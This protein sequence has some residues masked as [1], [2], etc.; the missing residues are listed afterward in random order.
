MSFFCNDH[1]YVGDLH[2]VFPVQET[3]KSVVIFI[4]GSVYYVRNL[5]LERRN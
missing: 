3:G 4:P 1:I 5:T 2:T